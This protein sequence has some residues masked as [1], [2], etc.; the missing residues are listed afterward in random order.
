MNPMRTPITS[1]IQYVSGQRLATTGYAILTD[2][3]GQYIGK[4]AAV[5]ADRIVV[6][7]NA[8]AGVAD[9]ATFIPDQRM[10]IANLSRERDA[11]LA[12]QARMEE[13]NA[14]LCRAMTEARQERDAA[15]SRERELRRDL[16]GTMRAIAEAQ[17]L[18]SD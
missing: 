9:P 11:A 1:A 18:L 17:A 5:D 15:L 6:C 2:A 10:T 12:T 8:C 3:A 13:A 14:T 4:V 7:V 16:D